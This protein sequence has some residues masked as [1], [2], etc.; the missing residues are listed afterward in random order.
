MNVS[1][2]HFVSG[3]CDGF[4]GTSLLVPAWWHQ[5]RIAG[6]GRIRFMATKLVG[7]WWQVPPCIRAKL[8]F[9]PFL[10]IFAFALILATISTSGNPQI[11][12]LAALDIAMDWIF[13]NMSLWDIHS[14][15]Q[16]ALLSP[17]ELQLVGFQENIPI[18]LY[19]IG[20]QDVF[21]RLEDAGTHWNS[22]R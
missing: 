18:S 7:I 19:G 14:F 2:R 1:H 10:F 11:H 15:R 12:Q 13:G 9:V 21:L 20:F 6:S 22:L 5:G 3:A 17:R 16:A 8:S 4:H